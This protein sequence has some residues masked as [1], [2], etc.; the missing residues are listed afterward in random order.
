MRVCSLTVYP[1]KGCQGVN[2][3]TMEIDR[4]GPVL[5]RRLMVVD[6]KSRFV[7]QRTDPNL[8]TVRVEVGEDGLYIGSTLFE[9]ML[10]IP[11]PFPPAGSY[12]Y[13]TVWKSQLGAV[14]LGEEAAMWFSRLLGRRARLVRKVSPRASKG[15]AIHG[16]QV[17][18]TF[19]D[20]YPI[21]LTSVESLG[22]LNNRL[23]E[24]GKH[25]VSMDRFRPNIVVEDV[26]HPF[27]EES[28]GGMSIGDTRLLGV[29]RCARCPV[30]T[31]DQVTGAVDPEDE[32]RAT[33]RELHSFPSVG[34][35]FGLNVD[36]LA[37]GTIRVGDSVDVLDRVLR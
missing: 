22:W 13:V 32:P 11:L 21:L 10:L 36:H 18:T 2:L 5:D 6:E 4:Q 33:L 17:E 30:I 12:H 1:I 9:R 8:A 26:H 24:R 31:T 15:T 25:P 27:D 28:F 7:T 37:T 19:A 35:A 23:V 14:D 29:S 34:P 16:E 3:T 20:G